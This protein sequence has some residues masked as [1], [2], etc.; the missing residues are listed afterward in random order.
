M[1]TDELKADLYRDEGLRLK[2]YLDTV[3]KTTIGVGRNLSDNGISK[4]EADQMLEHDI[5]AVVTELDLAFPWWTR[6]PETKR[7]ALA[8]MAFQLGLPRLK[9]FEKMLGALEAGDWNAAADEALDSTWA[10][11]V[12]ERAARIAQLFRS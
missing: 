8:N 12:P 2:P 7:R 5:A 1:N 3:G 4:L 9:G 10:R 11:Q 6:L